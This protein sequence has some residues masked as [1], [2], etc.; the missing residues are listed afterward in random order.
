VGDALAQLTAAGFELSIDDFGTGQSSLGRL[1]EIQVHELKLDRSLV[2]GIENDP[3]ARR[4]A[5][6]IVEL[7][8]DLGVEVLAEGIETEG[9]LAVLR[10]LGCA[11]GQGWLFGRPVAAQLLQV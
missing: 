2:R 6:L 7:G 10:E 5:R 9:Q 11:L 4:V 1:A 8:R 3:R